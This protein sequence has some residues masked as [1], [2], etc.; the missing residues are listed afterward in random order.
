MSEKPKV[1]LPNWLHR[2]TVDELRCLEGKIL[3]IL[4]AV[5]PEGQQNK[6]TKDLA[7]LEFNQALTWMGQHFHLQDEKKGFNPTTMDGPIVG[8]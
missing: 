1:Y 7:R 3:T 8:K 2:R 4:D 6:G 5:I